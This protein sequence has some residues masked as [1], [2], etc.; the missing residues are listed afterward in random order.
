M[1]SQSSCDT[2]P[3]WNLRV[4][5]PMQCFIPCSQGDLCVRGNQG[6]RKTDLR[7]SPFGA[8][9]MSRKVVLQLNVGERAHEVQSE[10]QAAKYITP[11]DTTMAVQRARGQGVAVEIEALSFAAHSHQER[12]STWR[13]LRRDGIRKDILCR[14]IGT[15]AATKGNLIVCLCR[16]KLRIG[17]VACLQEDGNVCHRSRES[18]MNPYNCATTG[19][20]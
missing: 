3:W 18:L 1:A 8:K 12:G 17:E 19:M 5:L 20:Q 16:E 7:Q 6:L 4:R 2:R 11:S 15:K 13:T 9:P 14:V 10:D